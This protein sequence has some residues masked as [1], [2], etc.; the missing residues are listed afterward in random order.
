MIKIPDIPDIKVIVTAIDDDIVSTVGKADNNAMNYSAKMIDNNL[1]ET[2]N[3]IE[4]SKIE[5]L[6]Q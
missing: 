5:R 3:K 4:M 2:N 1:I 6:V